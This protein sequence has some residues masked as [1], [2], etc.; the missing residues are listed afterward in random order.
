MGAVG[1]QRQVHCGAMAVEG[2]DGKKRIADRSG[3]KR[4]EIELN[5]EPLGE[6][7]RV[8]LAHPF[9]AR[10]I[11]WR[12]DRAAAL[13]RGTERDSWRSG[14]EPVGGVTG[15]TAGAEK[16]AAGDVDSL[17]VTAPFRGVIR[18]AAGAGALALGV[19]VCAGVAVGIGVTAGATGGG[20]EGAAGVVVGIGVAAGAAEGGA[21]GAGGGAGGGAAGAGGGAGG[22]AAGA[23]GVCGVGLA[24]GVFATGVAVG[25][26]RS[27]GGA[28]RSV[29]ADAGA[30]AEVPAGAPAPLGLRTAGAF[31]SEICRCSSTIGGSRSPPAAEDP[32]G[33][34][35]GTSGIAT[36]GLTSAGGASPV[37]DASTPESSGRIIGGGCRFGCCSSGI[38]SIESGRG[39]L[40]QAGWKHS[41]TSHRMRPAVQ[42]SSASAVWRCG[43]STAVGKTSQLCVFQLRRRLIAT[44]SA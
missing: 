43:R 8:G 13:A 3:N 36:L 29:G 39:R 7:G 34:G 28:R 14:A 37:D 4:Q 11:D 42:R 2:G 22:G 25:G 33:R 12:R 9:G 32:I 30:G 1:R 10:K 26:G 21:A 27:A 41:G 16:R 23:V 31:I 19:G 18:P 38:C 20:V 24:A 35:A 15:R 40:G 5:S 17:R 44:L 6:G